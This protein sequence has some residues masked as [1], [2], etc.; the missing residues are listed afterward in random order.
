MTR[1]RRWPSAPGTDGRRR[2][3]P[4]RRGLHVGEPP[5][6]WGSDRLEAIALTEPG[7]RPGSIRA[8]DEGGD[9]VR[10]DGRPVTVEVD[11][12]VGDHVVGGDD[13]V[14]AGLL[15][16]PIDAGRRS[17]ARPR[18]RVLGENGPRLV[19][20][21]LVQPEAETTDQLGDLAAIDY[22]LQPPLRLGQ[23]VLGD[24]QFMGIS[25]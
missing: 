12:D 16:D 3:A 10:S 15:S 6:F 25:P 21:L 18:R 9:Q 24:R 20:V 5:P 1:D 14:T 17:S 7:M 2:D 8:A 22:L 23:V 19:P 13:V 11:H 4:N